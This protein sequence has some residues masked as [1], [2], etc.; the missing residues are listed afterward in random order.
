LRPRTLVLCAVLL[1]VAGIALAMHFRSADSFVVA[2]EQAPPLPPIAVQPEHPRVSDAA[3][4]LAPFSPRLGRTTDAFYDDLGIDIQIVTSTESAQSIEAQSDQVFQKRK[5]GA[6]APTGGLLVLL[7]P[8]LASARIE[9]S[10]SLEHALTDLH[11]SRIARDQLAPYTSYGEAGM[12]VMDVLHYLSDQVYLA[13]AR[14]ELTL[15]ERFTN[16]PS[17][18]EYQRFVSGG[19]G[20]KTVLSTTPL[21][22]DLKR[23]LPVE[24]RARY[25]PSAD[26]QE[27]VDAFVRATADLAGDPSLELFTEGSQLMRAYYPLARFEELQRAE[28]IQAS[29]PLKILQQADY[30]VATSERPA[31]GFVPI[32]LHREM[33]LWRI[34]AVETW[35][36]LFFNGEGNYYLR[37][38]NTPYAFGLKQFGEGEYYDIAALPLQTGSIAA[39]LAALEGRHDTLSALRRAEILLRNAFVFP[40]A[41]AA[42]EAA[43]AASPKD[44]LVLETLASRA[45]YLGFPEIAIPLLEQV[46]RGM[47]LSLV[48][49]YNETGNTAAAERWVTRALAENPY[50]LYALQWQ[51]YLAEKAQRDAESKRL[52]EQMLALAKDPAG[53]IWPVRLSFNPRTP[54]FEPH[55]TLDVGGTKVFDHS[56][57]SV[58]LQN[59]SHRDI[60]IDTVM[61]TSLGT[62]HA[63]GLGDI[64]KYWSYPAGGTR[65]RARETVSFD[66]QWGFVEDTGHEHVRYVFRTC[67]HAVGTKVRQCRTQWVDVMP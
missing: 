11:M 6:G 27:S 58:F 41:Y 3:G 10:Y 42:Y 46:G 57:F 2:K 28:R 8:K 40:Q 4:I 35:K 5:I 53:G 49:A 20:A 1:V 36:N 29:L 17:Y 33:G 67:W 47:E 48:A 32:L 18:R 44:P 64:K 12:A 30:A 16:K 7:N 13:A 50:D 52:T 54:K 45:Q 59:P 55:T 65:V 61:L 56:K 66:K 60:E 9:V 37:N 62:A 15:N 19:A 25:A 21:D 39:E 31:K 23:K 24:Q 14:G 38:S 63:S 43:R 34:D 51:Q 26:I 22:A